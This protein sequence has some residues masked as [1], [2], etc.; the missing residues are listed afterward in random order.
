MTRHLDRKRRH[1]VLA[2]VAGLVAIAILAIAGYALTSPESEPPATAPSP[3]PKPSDPQPVKGPDPYPLLS[4]NPLERTEIDELVAFT[5]WLERQQAKGFIGELGWPRTT[6]DAN[7]W[8]TLADKW[9][10]VAQYHDVSSTAWAAG[11]MWSDDYALTIYGKSGEDRV[12]SA[13]YSQAET[14]EKFAAN[15]AVPTGVN[16][17]GLEFGTES[18]FNSGAPGVI[19]EAYFEEPEASFAYLARRGVTLVRL[20]FR[21]E[22]LQPTPFGDFAAESLDQLRR[23]LDSAAANGIQVILDLHNYGY[24]ESPS[25]PLQVGT[26]RL[27][28]DALTDVW[29]KLSTEFQSHDALYAYG[30]MNEPHDFAHTGNLSG[31]EF[32]EQI[33]QEVLTSIRNAGDETLIMVPGYNWSGVESWL[34]FHPDGW[35]NDPANNFRYEAHHY[36]DGDSSG[37][38]E[39]SYESELAQK[40]G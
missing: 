23:A 18:N 28:A 32:W 1:R 31:A 4:L 26:D 35:I 6:G 8:G 24:H 2:I 19:G 13:A 29:L 14:L 20:P 17:A 22:R 37:T 21:W 33:S 12:L 9:Y 25:G 7:P 5:G 11:S 15:V 39:D 36:W 38:Y 27:P 3:A 34:R 10:Q 30:L 16:L 40:G